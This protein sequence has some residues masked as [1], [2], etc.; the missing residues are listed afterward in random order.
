MLIINRYVTKEFLKIF[1]LCMATFFVIYFLVELFENLDDL[2]EQQI[3]LNTIFVYFLCLM[4]LIFF[5]VSPLGVLLSVFLT[6]GIFVRRNEITALKAHGISLYRVMT[7]FIGISFCVCCFSLFL[8]EYLMPYTN[9]RVK[10]IR[11]ID[12]KGRHVSKLL[13]H[14]HFWYREGDKIY[15]IDFFDAETETLDK[16]QIFFFSPEFTLEKKLEARTARF[17]RDTKWLLEDIVIRDFQADGTVSLF[18]I[19]TE[20]V[21]LH[22]TPEDFKAVQKGA[23][24][25]SISEIS[26]FIKTMR[27]QGYPTTSYLVEMHGKISYPFINIIMALL[28]IPFALRIGRSGGMAF[29]ITLSIAIGFT[30]WVFFGFCMSLGKGGALPPVFSAWLANLAFGS[31]GGYMFTHVR[32]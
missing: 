30:Y 32:Q 14:H 4:P 6:L 21:D 3:E 11:N 31:L 16:I 9:I 22:K 1:F 23:E 8:Q 12:I 29:G 17:D 7:I 13:K 26:E 27:R 18:S 20:T 25:M 19:Y 15:S 5:Q 2:V 24:E 28:G 10:E